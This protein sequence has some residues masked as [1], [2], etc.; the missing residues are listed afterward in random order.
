MFVGDG[1]NDSLALAQADVGVSLGSGTD[2]A[3]SAADVVVL[4]TESGGGTG[5]GTDLARALRVIVGVSRGAVRRV[6]VNFAWAFVYNTVAVL[7][8]AGAFADARISL[9]TRA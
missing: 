4:D 3:L 1:T 2:I 8:A 5:T 9:R 6:A 7:F